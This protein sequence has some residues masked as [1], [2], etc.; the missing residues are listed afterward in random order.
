MGNIQDKVGRQA[1]KETEKLLK[2]YGYWALLVQKGPNGQPFDVVACKEKENG[3]KIT[4]FVDVKHLKEKEVSFPFDRVESNQETSMKYARKFAGIKEY[5]GFVI[6][7][8]RAENRFLFLDYDKFIRLK[9]KG[10]KSV[11][12]D[13]LVNYEDLLCTL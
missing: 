11:K 8:E 6:V 2:K 13:E 10:L 1:E 3:E 12:I 9:E 4:W 7:L 5:L